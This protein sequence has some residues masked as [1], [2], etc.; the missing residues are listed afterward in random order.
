MIPSLVALIGWLYISL[1]GKTSRIIVQDHPGFSPLYQNTSPFLYVFWHRVQFFL[2]YPHRRENLAVLVS[3]SKDGELIARVLR[4]FG[5]ATIRGSSSRGGVQ[6]LNE[7]VETLK[8]GTRVAVTPDGPRGP[9]WTVHPGAALVA[10]KTGLPVVPVACAA[11]RALVFKSWDEY[12]VPLPFNRIALVHGKPL[13]LD[14]ARSM[15]EHCSLI[16]ESLD[17]VM[18]EAHSLL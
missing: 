3:L 12:I 4:R 1:V 17:S 10:L 6:A 14:P 11:R 16:R 9:R 13:Y 8:R 18:K 7:M 2:A 15:D 5:L